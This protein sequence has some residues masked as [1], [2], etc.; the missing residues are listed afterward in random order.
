MFMEKLTGFMLY[1]VNLLIFTRVK[2][3]KKH[4][5]AQTVH[6]NIIT[7]YYI[8]YTHIQKRNKKINISK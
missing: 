4:L 3:E 1:Y 2:K 5:L 6:N 8:R 7:Y